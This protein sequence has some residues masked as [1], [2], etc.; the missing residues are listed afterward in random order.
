MVLAW[1]ENLPEDEM[2]P[3]WM[4]TLPEELDRHFRDVRAKRRNGQHDD[5]E[6]ITGPV[7]ENEYARGRG[8]V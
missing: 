6:E 3:R 5:D 1:Q 2:P 4:W 7:I 8:R